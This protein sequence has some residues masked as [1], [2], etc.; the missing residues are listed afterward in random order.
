MR[1]YAAYKQ[2]AVCNFLFHVRAAS[3]VSDVFKL[4]GLYVPLGFARCVAIA[5]HGSSGHGW[6]G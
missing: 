6:R 4:R 1:E 3:R 2:R 5:F